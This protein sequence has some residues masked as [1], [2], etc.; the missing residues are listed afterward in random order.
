MRGP[1]Q[2][3]EVSLPAAQRQRWQPIRGGLLNI[4]RYD[5]QEFQ[6]EDGRLLLRGNNGTGKSRVLALQLPF[7]LDG[8]I[9]PQRVEPDGDPAKRMEWNLLLGGKH[10]DRLGYTWVEF[11]RLTE[12]G[13]AEYKTL[14]C[15]LRAV[16]GRGVAQQWFF[17]TSQRIGRDLF[18]ENEAGQPLSKARLEAAIGDKGKVFGSGKIE[19]DR[20]DYR[21]A[22]NNE[23]FKLGDRYDA[24]INLLIQL[25]QPQLSRTLNEERLSNALSQALPPL[26]DAVL[27]DVAEAFRSLETDRS[28]LTDFKA[29]RDSA[30]LFLKE[31]QRYVQI[32]ARRR[33]E[34]LRTTHSAYEATMRRL[35]TAESAAEQATR[36]LGGLKESIDQLSIE[37]QVAMA[38]ESTLR[39]S[40][41]MKDAKALE[42][43]R[44]AAE[45]AQTAAENARRESEQATT[46][47]ERLEQQRQ[48][49]VERVNAISK[50]AQNIA[51]RASNAAGAAGLKQ[52]HRSAIERLG[53]G[54]AD[55]T[56]LDPVAASLRD[57]VKHWL[58]AARHVGK[59][60]QQVEAA[61]QQLS[62]AQQAFA[63]IEGQLN[64]TIEGEREAGASVKSE[65]A[66]LFV[67]YRAWA[68]RVSE[69]KSAEADGIEPAF[70]DW[71]DLPEGD[72]PLTRAIKDAERLASQRIESGRAQVGARLNTARE[73]AAALEIEFNRLRDGYHE[74]PPPPHAR[75]SGLRANRPGAPLWALCDFLPSTP[76]ADR[77]NIEAALEA[78]GLLDA[79][80]TAEGRLLDPNEHDTLLAVGISEPAPKGQALDAVLAP[81]IDRN[82]PCA[83][84]VSEA[85]VSAVLRHIGFGQ[86]AGAVWVAGD[87]RWQLGPLHGAWSKGAAQHI[88]HAS[89]ESARRQRM[90]EVKAQLETATGENSSIELELGGLEQRSAQ[91]H[92]EVAQAPTDGNVRRA[93]AQLES[94]R[95][96]VGRM[97]LRLAEVE[98]R[99]TESRRTMNAATEERDRAAADLG[100]AEWID[101]LTD[102]IE[103]VHSYSQTLAEWWPAIR[104]RADAQLQAAA[105]EERV[106]EASCTLTLRNTQ[107]HEAK[108]KAAAA[109]ERFRTL[110][111]TVGAAVREVQQRLR[112][113]TQRVERVRREKQ[114]TEEDNKQKEIALAVTRS[115]IEDAN[116]DLKTKD[117]ERGSAVTGLVAFVGT[118][119][120][121][122]AHGDFAATEPGP[123]SVARAVDLARRIE[124]ALSGVDHGNEAWTRNQ[125]DIHNH[126]E[127]LQS[128]LRAHGYM[129]EASMTDGLFVVS[130]QFQGRSCTIADLRDSVVTIIQERQELLDARERE[131]LENYL[132]DEVAEH[133]HDLLHRALKWKEEIN[134]ELCERP[135]S[136]GMRLRFVWEPLPDMSPVFAEARGLLLSA[137]GTWSPAQRAAVGQFLQQQIK[138][139]RAAN[140][141][142]TWQDHLAQAFDY[143]KWHQ[144]G[145]ERKQD[146]V[147]KRLTRRTHGTGSGGE[148]AI[149]LTLP[150]LAAAA[151][152]YR[153]ADKNAPRLILLDEAFVGVDKNMRAK[154]MDLL[155]VFDLDVVMT[156]ESEWAC[157]PTVPAIAIYQ[158]AAREGIDAVHA[159]RW[160]WNGKQRVRDD[161]PLPNARPPAT[162]DTARFMEPP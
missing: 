7:L 61:R 60:N 144:F 130:I 100:I 161:S 119:Q 104:A 66:A 76:E 148:K 16:Q 117:L 120:L 107:F 49:A 142:G 71:C 9:V 139:V 85:T 98:M 159:T 6:Y 35:R 36:E 122:V 127:T 56:R 97:R 146:G 77:A 68:S 3:G 37:E 108:G 115:K 103:A 125:R 123:W 42:D 46:A 118:R 156:S 152:H 126:F 11:G 24:L 92:G 145:V 34:E 89:R 20:R 113:A 74:P 67:S 147:W 80:V 138:A 54:G 14:G 21:T 47:L 162:I 1:K 88:G 94:A 39:D 151:A 17:I 12:G 150:Q 75:G 131:V 83:S 15:A 30:E 109:L 5:Y 111:G 19:D 153:T 22:I 72:S 95:Q 84:A 143:R 90:T 55:A 99:V 45:T 32:A 91:L 141:T 62:M 25:R 136:T 132:I 40:P 48:T 129:P 160:V 106:S 158:L 57:L 58:E 93:L 44:L 121:A 124:A 59:L 102:L 87:G 8:E 51:E 26:P 43:A 4:Y 78:S 52:P 73:L 27:G 13:E 38:A 105:A 28:E 128:S 137:R 41:E 134:E 2:N 70:A 155:R 149:A 133:L 82:D 86:G 112:D 135:M 79:W 33:A 157:Y 110:E 18:L 81:S 140:D 63:Q 10:D 96:A 116:N 29:A 101:K 31:Y 65:T 154:C 23:L 69:L 114:Q 64:E 53:G 50:T